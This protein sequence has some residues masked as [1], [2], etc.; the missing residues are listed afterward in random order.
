MVGLEEPVDTAHPPEP[1]EALVTKPGPLARWELLAYLLILLLALSLRLWD[2][3]SQAIH[4]D[5]SLHGV[6][7]WYLYQGRG[8]Q[9]DPMMHGPFQF[10]STASIFW[11]LWDSGAGVRLL[12]ALFGTALVGMPLLLRGYLGRTGTL[13]T[14]ILLTFSPT[15]LYFSRF[16]R[17]DMFM[18]VWTLALVALMWRYLDTRKMRYLVWT[19]A[20][21]ALAFATKETTYI[22]VMVLGGYLLIYAAADVVPWF[23]GRKRLGEFSPAGQFLVLVATLSLPLAGGGLALFQEKLGLTLANPEWTVG[24]VGVPMGTGLFVA[25]FVVVGLF[26][27]AVAV[28]MRWRWRLWLVCFGAFGTIWVLLYTSFFTNFW[29]GL[30]SGLWQSLGY[31]VV[32]QDVARGG[33]PWYYFLVLGLNYEFLPMLVGIAAIGYFVIRG[34]RFS[35]FLVYWAVATFLFHTYASEKM[36][37]LLVGVSL[38]FF[39]L[40]GKFLGGLLD[41]RPWEKAGGSEGEEAMVSRWT[42]RVHRSAVAFPVMV[43]MLVVAA[44]W[45]LVNAL[46]A[47]PGLSSA[48]ALVLLGAVGTLGAGCVYLLWRIDK[49][50][51]GAVIGV[52]L[53]AVMLAMTIPS[54]FRVAYANADVPVE[55]LVYTQTAPDIP[56]VMEDI[57]RLGEETGKG[58]DLK[59]TVDSTDGFS[60]PWAWY[61]RDYTA[62]GYPCLGSDTGCQGIIKEPDADVVL[63]AARSQ[64]VA[65]G[66]MSAYGEPVRYKHRWWFPESYRGLDAKT[67]FE[68]IFQRES[69]CRVA[70][71]FLAREFGQGIGSVDAYAYFPKDF[72]PSSGGQEAVESRSSC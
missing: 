46:S 39:I 29:G 27:L 17:N 56:K 55:L 7:S 9:H 54:A 5:E 66:Y 36:P 58:R 33:Q 51:R 19:A 49:V 4:H 31:W 26:A 24:P 40:A 8:Y 6:Y 50:K 48:P 61:L 21:L 60:W 20:V 69:W 18:A 3:G 42:R 23:L 53:A 14:S 59:I 11:L 12:P 67:I 30:G 10:F 15:M 57:R 22:L 52:S 37:W 16:A 63:L 38:P 72:A 1:A 45:W 35:R 34:D 68:G 43:A 28:G 62:V 64:L 32:Q 44:G 13:A 65:G 71:Y 2:L 47:E 25:F 41:R 70:K